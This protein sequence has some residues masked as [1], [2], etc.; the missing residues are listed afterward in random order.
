MPSAALEEH[1]DDEVKYLSGEVLDG[2]DF[3]HTMKLTSRTE[4]STLISGAPLGD[5]FVRPAKADIKMLDRITRRQLEMDLLELIVN[6]HYL[7]G[8]LL[9]AEEYLRTGGDRFAVQRT[10]LLA[11]EREVQELRRQLE[12][13]RARQ[14]QQQV[15]MAAPCVQGGRD[16]QALTVID[17]VI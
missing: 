17:A 14:Q 12:E 9:K 16:R 5:H 4:E 3:I 2:L 7:G 15:G 10:R 13:L 1:S 8:K 11:A 6:H